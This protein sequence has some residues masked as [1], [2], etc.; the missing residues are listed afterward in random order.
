R[1]S[2]A[3]DTG[4]ESDVGDQA[5]HGTEDRRPQPPAGHVG[6]MVLRVRGRNLLGIG[7]GRVSTS[8]PAS[9]TSTGCSNCAAQ[10]RSF[11]TTV[12]PSGHSSCRYV[13][14][15]IIGSIVKFIPGSM[16]TPRDG[17]S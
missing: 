10:R 2:A 5:V 14:S 12:H 4:D 13:P 16:S 8:W 15:V 7:H 1:D 11:V 3:G 6:V 17:L 9:V